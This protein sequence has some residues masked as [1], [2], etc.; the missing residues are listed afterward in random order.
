MPGMPTIAPSAIRLKHDAELC[1][2]PPPVAQ[3]ASPRSVDGV[4]WGGRWCRVDGVLH[5]LL[6]VRPHRPQDRPILEVQ[7]SLEIGGSSQAGG[8]PRWAS[9]CT[10]T[11]PPCSPQRP[12]G[13]GASAPGSWV[14]PGTVTQSPLREA[15]AVER[16]AQMYAVDDVPP[17]PEVRAHVRSSC[18]SSRAQNSPSRGAV[19]DQI[20]AEGRVAR[21][22]AADGKLRRE[23]DGEPTIGIGREREE[24]RALMGPPSAA[25]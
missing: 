14:A 10:K 9:W 16:A 25:I 7:P 17:W 21:H 11:T 1:G 6:R 23:A 8:A 22:H 18:G 4:G 3:K 15:P 5:D 19:D 24:I 20:L 2:R 13:P 12:R